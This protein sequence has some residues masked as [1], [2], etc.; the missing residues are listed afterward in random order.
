MSQEQLDNALQHGS[1]T[2]NR[3][4]SVVYP[5]QNTQFSFGSTAGPVFTGQ[6]SFGGQSGFSRLK[7]KRSWTLPNLF[8]A[9]AGVI[10]V[11]SGGAAALTATFPST[12]LWTSEIVC[13]GPNQLMVNTSH[14]SYRPGQSGTSVDFACLAADGAHNANFFMISLLQTLM[15]ALIFAGVVATV[16]LIRRLSR[17]EPLRPAPAFLCGAAALVALVVVAFMAWQAIGSS[18]A[19][20]QMPH[21]GNLSIRGN[22]DHQTI[23]CNNG[24][25]SVDGR[26]M[27]VTVTGHCARLSVDGVISHITVDS[28]DAID[29][30]GVNN[31]VIYHSGVPTI[32]RSGAQNSVKQG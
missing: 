31:V 11:C 8:G 10:G 25:L 17:R 18:S 12:A 4:H 22:G 32:T 26:D 13:G 1:V 5:E 7:P 6:S 9:F 27:T 29:I 30:D 23:A 20:T 24:H 2:V 3:G 15:V 16:Y 28:A 14:Y 21:G 19:A